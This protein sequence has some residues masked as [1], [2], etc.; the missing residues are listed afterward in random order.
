VQFG[1][2][3][4]VSLGTTV[5]AL[6]NAEGRGGATPS[7][8]II[9]A[10]NRSIQASDEGSDTTESLTHMLQTS[11]QIQPGDSGGALA[12][13]AGQVI[14]MITAANSGTSGQTGSSGSGLGYAIPIN[15]ALSLARQMA[16]GISSSNV[17]IGLPGFLGVEVAQ[18]TSANPQQQANDEQ[19]SGGTGSLP[20]GNGPACQSSN[21]QLSIP[22]KIAPARSG[23]LILGVLC[24]TV[25]QEKGLAPGDV[26]TSVDGQPVTTPGS[27]TAITAKYHPGTT[28]S[29]GWEST[30]GA[31]HTTSMTLGSGPAR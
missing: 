25:V 16:G 6:G 1:N 17:Y 28:V 13:N 20:T 2:S 5:L 12:D 14:G 10:L 23:A 31:R 29:V 21:A 9:N 22:D 27:L 8:G 18:S 19:Q 3:S 4:Q 30:S 15:S 11:A 7:K 24:G 26:I